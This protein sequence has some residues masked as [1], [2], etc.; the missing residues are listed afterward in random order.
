V[1][2]GLGGA[3]AT[4]SVKAGWSG[5]AQRRHP[6]HGK[7]GSPIGAS[8]IAEAFL[9]ASILAGCRQ[10]DRAARSPFGKKLPAKVAARAGHDANP[11]SNAAGS[12]H[13][14]RFRQNKRP[15]ADAERSVARILDAAVDALASDPEA[16]M[17]GSLAAPASCARRST[18]TSGHASR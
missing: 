12:R 18:S 9:A 1:N 3:T 11:L 17:A 10:P 8:G 15:R 2:V 7:R 13:S 5:L 16:S 4:D 14:Q 6:S